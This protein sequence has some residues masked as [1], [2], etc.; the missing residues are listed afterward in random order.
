MNPLDI[1]IIVIVGIG[2][3]IGLIKGIIRIV[4]SF[5]GV[6][7]GFL[8]ATRFYEAGGDIAGS[9]IKSQKAAEITAFSLIFVVIVIAAVIL[10]FLITKAMKKAHLNWINRLVGG[11]LGGLAGVFIMTAVIFLLTMALPEDSSALRD[12]TLAPYIV[13][14]NNAVVKMVPESLKERYYDAKEKLLEYKDKL[15]EDIKKRYEE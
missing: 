6:V 2:F 4:F 15:E 8:V 10:G 3:I 5:A 7:I 11:A 12:S 13:K 9:I 14:I 1:V